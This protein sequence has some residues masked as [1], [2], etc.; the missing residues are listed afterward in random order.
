MYTYINTYIYIYNYSTVKAKNNLYMHVGN[1]H[2]Y[3]HIP[4]A[5]KAKDSRKPPIRTTFLKKLKKYLKTISL[6]FICPIYNG[7]ISILL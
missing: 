1:V 3:T 2:I 5:E 6:V 4:T 7:V